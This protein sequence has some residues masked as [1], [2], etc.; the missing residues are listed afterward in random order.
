MSFCCV[1]NKTSFKLRDTYDD[2]DDSSISNCCCCTHIAQQNIKDN[3]DTH[4]KQGLV[5]KHKLCGGGVSL[6][7]TLG[8]IRSKN[9]YISNKLL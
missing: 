7:T 5:E 3:I 4:K 2:D 9:I 6:Y 8:Y 1:E